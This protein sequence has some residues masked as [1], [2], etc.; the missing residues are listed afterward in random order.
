MN[1]LDNHV[2]TS[3]SSDGKD[4]ME[5]IIKR[6]VEIG[7]SHLTFTDHL[8]YKKGK[9]SIDCKK[10]CEKIEGYKEKYNNDIELLTGIEVGF[11][12][13]AQKELENIIATTPFD[14]VLCSTHAVDKVSVSRPQ[15]YRGYSKKEAYQKYFESIIEAT[16]LFK[17]FDSYG[18]LDYIIRY[19][20]YEDNKLAYSDYKNVIDEVLKNI[21]SSGKGIELNTSGYRYGLDSIHPNVDIVKRYKELGGEI[22]TVGSDSHRA[23]D[24]CKDF[25]KAYDML[26][27]L[28]FKYVCLFKNRAPIFLPLDKERESS[29]A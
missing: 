4:T 3:F 11:Q 13:H 16:K 25:D 9:I 1:L 14:F 26:S 20:I 29:I 7:V 6:S 28:G 21:I 24:V 2:H 23:I 27:Y 12:K 8:E 17:N 10:Y 19:A 22:I 15:Y 5:S 18:H